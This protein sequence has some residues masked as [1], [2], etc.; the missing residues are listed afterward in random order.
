MF[1]SDWCLSCSL[2]LFACTHPPVSVRMTTR[3][4]K[5]MNNI[6]ISDMGQSLGHLTEC[7][8]W[9]KIFL[10]WSLLSRKILENQSV[11]TFFWTAS[12]WKVWG[13]EEVNKLATDQQLFAQH[14]KLQSF[15]DWSSPTSCQEVDTER[16]YFDCRHV[17]QGETGHI[18]TLQLSCV[19][20][21]LSSASNEIIIRRRWE[22]SSKQE[23][24]FEHLVILKMTT[25]IHW[26]FK[27]H[28]CN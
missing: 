24:I 3:N 28:Q 19:V 15:A 14:S 26:V 9:D 27:N 6:L 2:S 1:T 4:Q 16:I 22:A 5:L 13:D 21:G 12:S 23:V 18:H 10:T 7:W 25:V 17:C 11:V 8:Q 20:W